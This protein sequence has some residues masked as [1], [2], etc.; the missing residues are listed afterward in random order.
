LTLLPRM[1]NV[2]SL[3]MKVSQAGCQGL[4]P[5]TRATQGGRDLEDFYLKPAPGK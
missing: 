5:V 2:F 1:N 3:S 4:T